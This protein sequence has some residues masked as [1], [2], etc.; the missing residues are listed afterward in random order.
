VPQLPVDPFGFVGG[1][2]GEGACGNGGDN[3]G[4]GWQPWQ[5]APPQPAM[6]AGGTFAF[7]LQLLEPQWPFGGGFAGLDR[8]EGGGGL[9]G[10]QL[11]RDPFA[12]QWGACGG[13]QPAEAQP[14]GLLGCG[15]GDAAA[16]VA[17]APRQP[18]Q[19]QARFDGFA[20]LW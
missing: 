19:P 6:A 7:G 1:G 20:P 4:A 5:P 8:P 9:S 18:P 3:G 15:G 12:Q 14:W 11:P 17:V 16:V 10:A 13:G 2:L